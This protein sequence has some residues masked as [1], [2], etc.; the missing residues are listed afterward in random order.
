LSDYFVSYINS[1]VK[2]NGGDIMGEELFIGTGASKIDE[3][4]I[5]K[6]Q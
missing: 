1:T 2:I 4:T 3:V 6:I 5:G